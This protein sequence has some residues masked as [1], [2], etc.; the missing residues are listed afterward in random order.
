MAVAIG[1]TGGI[2]CGKSAV[3]IYLAD[4][5]GCIRCDADR[6]AFELL[7]PGMAGWQALFEE[8][9]EAYLDRA[10]EVDR[11]KLRQAI[12]FDDGVR[13]RID[14]LLHPLVRRLAEEQIAIHLEVGRSVLVEVPLL[15]EAGWQD[16]FA[17]V[18]V[19][20]AGEAERLRRLRA[21]DALSNDD[22]LAALAA[23]KG[24][25]EK[26]LRA[27]HVVDNSGPWA[28]TCLVLHRLAL[29]LTASGEGKGLD[30]VAKKS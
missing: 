17:R 23:Q 6:L 11:P 8:F 28:D 9:G 4:R 19:V 30:C 20:Y 25:A 10:G 1:I 3:S 16:M 21:R 27:D 29:L 24:L 13:R 22:A 14:A 2:A 26:A 7:R 15:Y 12:F 5:C 18:I